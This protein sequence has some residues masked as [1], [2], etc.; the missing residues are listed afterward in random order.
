[1]NFLKLDHL[2]SPPGVIAP[3]GVD[4]EPED[5]L[6]KI[7]KAFRLYKENKEEVQLERYNY[8]R[9][10]IFGEIAS[11]LHAQECE[12]LVGIYGV[13][14]SQKFLQLPH[15]SLP[16]VMTRAVASVSLGA[17]NYIFFANHDFTKH[18]I[19]MQRIYMIDAIILP[20]KIYTVMQSAYGHSAR[21]NMRD[22]L[23]ALDVN[24]IYNYNDAKFDG[25]R[26][27]HSRPHHFFY[28]Q[29]RVLNVMVE[30]GYLSL[31]KSLYIENSFYDIS[32]FDRPYQKIVGG[33]GVLIRPIVYS[34]IA[35]PPKK[36][37]WSKKTME[38]IER[39]VYQDAI[40][41]KILPI[42]PN[43]DLKIWIGVTG[44]KRSWIE[45]IQGYANI[46]N[47]FVASGHT[48]ALVIDGMTAS[49]EEKIECPE[50]QDVAER[51]VRLLDSTVYV[52]NLIGLD[53]TVK[54]QIC[55]E[56]DFFIANGGTGC[57]VPLR[58]CK[59]PG[60]VHS[61]TQLLFPFDDDY[62]NVKLI[63]QKDVVTDQKSSE[64]SEQ[65]M[66]ISYHIQWQVIFNALLSVVPADKSVKC[67]VI[68][69]HQGVSFNYLD[70]ITAFKLMANDM[71]EKRL[72]VRPDRMLHVLRELASAFASLGHFDVAYE[73]IMFALSKNYS[74]EILKELA[75]DYKQKNS[76]K[77]S[78]CL[79][80]EAEKVMWMLATL[81]L[82][83]QLNKKNIKIKPERF[84]EV[85][86]LVAHGMDSIGRVEI[87]QKIRSV[88]D[89]FFKLN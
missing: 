78:L 83:S 81:Q 23:L 39:R 58:F 2:L 77:N 15:P 66:T 67:R 65:A 46:V 32:I 48:V 85:L 68:D 75:V 13:L 53:Y 73:M 79:D 59:K 44:Q 54:V 11:A 19:Y 21:N 88:C 51:I 5:R 55:D 9:P 27:G 6:R 28:D 26:V 20:R 69:V 76:N 18:W 57:M 42:L 61:N 3:A 12:K 74:S 37:E 89:A 33:K 25:V 87:S 72:I 80:A 60:V 86:Q 22:V 43:V 62:K 50:D 45:Q 63:N 56:V 4:F 38:S 14:L 1:M 82:R 29:M 36:N 10:D 84:S 17:E 24:N 16:N 40:S 47:Q 71:S 7:K 52:V 35:I 64:S 30:R 49:H 41:K 70:T 8:K 31:N 34:A